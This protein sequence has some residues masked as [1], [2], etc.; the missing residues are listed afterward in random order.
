MLELRIW[1]LSGPTWS[2]GVPAVRFGAL[3]R[4]DRAHVSFRDLFGRHLRSVDGL[5][6]FELQ[7]WKLLHFKRL[8]L[9]ELCIGHLS[10]FN[11]TLN[12]T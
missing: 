11:E 9:F 7:C 10:G 12:F 1:L 5:R 6:L 4:L 8:E 2:I 3:L